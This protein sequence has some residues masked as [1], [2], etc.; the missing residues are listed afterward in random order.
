VV[1][2]YGGKDGKGRFSKVRVAGISNN[3]DKAE[4]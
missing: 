4:L 1:S 2:K 3:D